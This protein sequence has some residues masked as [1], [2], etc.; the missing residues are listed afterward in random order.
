MKKIVRCFIIFMSL[1]LLSGYPSHGEQS[2]TVAFGGDT[3]FGGYYSPHTDYGTM[4]EL[5]QIINRYIHTHGEQTGIKLFVEYAFRNIR[6]LFDRADYGMANLEGPITT[7]EKNAVE[8]VF[9]LKQHVR[10]PE[11]LKEAGIAL[12]SV[13]NNHSYDFNRG[14]ALE[15]TMRRLEAAGIEYVGAGTGINA[16]AEAFSCKIRETNGVRIA[17]FGVTDVIEPQDMVARVGKT[18]VAA[19][20]EQS[21][22]RESKDMQYLLR[23]IAEARK[24]AD[25]AV[26]LLHAGPHRGRELN[27]RQREIVDILLEH[28]VDV[29][30]GAHC[31]AKQAIKEVTDGQGTLKQVA[32][33]GLGNLIFGGSRTSRSPGLI[34]LITFCKGNNAPYLTYEAFTIKP[35]EGDDHYQPYL[36]YDTET[37]ISVIREDES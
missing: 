11:I 17:F 6:H 8:K 7:A 5:T 3:L 28:G 32:F 33:Y 19:L 1:L 16:Y 12:V 29:V 22:Y 37:V 20:P 27:Q 24:A 18:G 30:I 25:F 31:H 14:K 2:V 36:V 4:N 34:P 26:V 35:G 9:P 10:T 15:E 21:N 23:N 13:A